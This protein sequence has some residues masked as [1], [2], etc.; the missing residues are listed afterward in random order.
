MLDNGGIISGYLYFEAAARKEERLNFRFEA[1][2]SD[3]EERVALIR[4]PFR[5]Q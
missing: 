1:S 3:R 2:E 4:I 5:V